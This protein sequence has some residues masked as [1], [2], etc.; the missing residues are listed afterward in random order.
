LAA[1][2]LQNQYAGCIPKAWT[3]ISPLQSSKGLNYH[4]GFS[5]GRVFPRKPHFITGDKERFRD[6]S[7]LLIT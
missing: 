7:L 2:L 6:L 3:E 5:K 1:C 4:R